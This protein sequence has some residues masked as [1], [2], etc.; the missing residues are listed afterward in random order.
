MNKQEELIKKLKLDNEFDTEN[1]RQLEAMRRKTTSEYYKSSHQKT[2]HVLNAR[3]E[4]RRE[5]LEFI[6]K[7]RL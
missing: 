2:I 4:L 5:I 1:V 3:R 7:E 6:R